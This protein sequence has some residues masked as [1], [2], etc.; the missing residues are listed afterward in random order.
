[1]APLAVSAWLLLA[2]WPAM[3]DEPPVR[4]S[5]SGGTR[6]G[7]VR[8]VVLRQG[9]YGRAVA[10]VQRRLHQRADGVFGSRLKRA[11]KRFQRRR[12]MEVDGI[13]GPKTRRALRLHSFR[14]RDVHHRRRGG[15]GELPGLPRVLHN[16][17]LCESGGN[18]RAVSANGLYR[19]KYQFDRGTWERW[20]GS[21]DPARAPEQTQDR[22]ALRLYRREGTRPWPV[23]GRSAG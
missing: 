6:A 17:A 9:D 1:M 14:R 18:P 23:C 12:H 2:A 13:V 22:L 11:V 7:K 20:G 3:A 8:F 16:I 19:G 10:R 21:G 5:S 15:S 4:A